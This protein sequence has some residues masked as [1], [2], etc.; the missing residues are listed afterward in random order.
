MDLEG[1]FCSKVHCTNF[2]FQFCCTF[3]SVVHGF[4]VV[5]VTFC[6]LFPCQL[7]EKHLFHAVKLLFDLEV[8]RE[9]SDLALVIFY[10]YLMGAHLVSTFV[11]SIAAVRCYNY[12]SLIVVAVFGTLNL[13]Q[14]SAYLVFLLYIGFDLD[15]VIRDGAIVIAAIALLELLTLTLTARL[16]ADACKEKD[17]QRKV[18]HRARLIQNHSAQ[19]PLLVP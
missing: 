6:F 10:A 3:L 16:L 4:V 18:M 8:D 15:L 14:S 13:V 9:G 12:Y 5:K 2:W 19:E 17:F 11:Y 1:G 7:L